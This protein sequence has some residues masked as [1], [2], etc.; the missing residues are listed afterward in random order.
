MEAVTADLEAADF[1]LGMLD[2]A[3]HEL[4]FTVLREVR[5]GAGDFTP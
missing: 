1:G 5:V 4:L 3:Q 2:P